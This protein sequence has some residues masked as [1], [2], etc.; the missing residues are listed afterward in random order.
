MTRRALLPAL[1]YD[2]E[3]VSSFIYPCTCQHLVGW[4]QWR[5]HGRAGQGSATARRPA[6]S[7]HFLSEPKVHSNSYPPQPQHQ[8]HG[9]RRASG[10]T[11]AGAMFQTSGILEEIL[12]KEMKQEFLLCVLGSLEE[13]KGLRAPLQRF[14]SKARRAEKGAWVQG[15]PQFSEGDAGSSWLS[16]GPDLRPG[17]R[18]PHA[19][20][21]WSGEGDRRRPSF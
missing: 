19:W 20:L 3:Q 14:W 10:D 18:R 7:G 21:V 5:L 1:D 4:P 2:E 16:Q 6:L 11:G 12:A 8:T 15:G 13:H 9:A 17:L